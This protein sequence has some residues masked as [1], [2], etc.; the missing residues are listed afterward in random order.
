MS[1]EIQGADPVAAH[2]AACIDRGDLPGAVWRVEDARGVRWAGAAGL[3][4]REP[5]ELPAEPGLLYDLASVTKAAS[6]AILCVLTDGRGLLGLEASLVSA[7]PELEG[8][9]YAEATVRDALLHRTGLPAW[10]PLY[11]LAER[12]EAIPGVAAGLAAGPRGRVLYSDL[13]PILV[14]IALARAARTGLARMFDA[15]IARP[16]GLGEELRFLTG[17]TPLDRIAPTERGTAKE[18]ELAAS[19]RGRPCR[20]D[21][22]PDR[23]LHGEVHDNNARFLGG[24]AGHAGLFATA[25]ALA[26]LGRE[27]LEPSGRVLDREA[28]HRLL[29]PA[30]EGPDGVRRCLLGR[31]ARGGPTPAAALS[32]R[33]AGHVGFTGP[34]WFLDPEDG[35]VYVLLT[36]RV[37]PTDRG[38]DMGPIRSAFHEMA[39]ARPP[40][41][42]IS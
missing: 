37:H 35:S 16:L 34:S 23:L 26:A 4:S 10:A 7:L 2:I 31:M 25:R 33:A 32:S 11:C 5:G 17:G 18:R 21:V 19:F 12:P 15:W 14:G 13:G 36:N 1:Q 6:T 38:V 3:A 39:A 20:E 9:P 40:G 28:A 42:R 29:E 30:A 22:W 27:V 8:S 24:A 41:E